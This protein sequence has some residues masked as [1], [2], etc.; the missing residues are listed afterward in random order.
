MKNENENLREKLNR[1]FR[2]LKVLKKR[3]HKLR[4]KNKHLSEKNDEISEKFKSLKEKF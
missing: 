2:H 1:V 3:N 4:H